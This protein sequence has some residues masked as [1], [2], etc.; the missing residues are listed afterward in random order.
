[1]IAHS[2][3]RQG[4]LLAKFIILLAVG[5]L[6]LAILFQVTSSVRAEQLCESRLQRIHRALELYEIERGTLPQLSFYPD[7]PREGPDSLRGALENYGVEY[8]TCVCPRAPRLLREAGQTYLWNARLSGQ[9]M[10]R[11]STPVWMLVDMAALSSDVP[12]PHW[13]GYHVLF[14]DGSVKRVRDPQRELEG[15]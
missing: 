15:L 5:A 1:M 10:P 14:S 7:D 3:S 9:K 6:A 12:A 13:D 11:G 4:G 8:E 2:A